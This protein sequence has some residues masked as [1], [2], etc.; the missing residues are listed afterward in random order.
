MGVVS[1]GSYG[2]PK[3]KINLKIILIYFLG[4]VF[5]YP[6]TCQDGKWNIVQGLSWSAFSKEQIEK[7]TQEL[8]EERTLALGD[9]K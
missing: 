3:G 2:I 4:I 5:S 7:T 9:K 6:V 1:D 8:L